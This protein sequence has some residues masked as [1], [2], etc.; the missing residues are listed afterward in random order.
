MTPDTTI[1]PPMR[2]PLNL[3]QEAVVSIIRFA[4]ETDGVEKA[5]EFFSMLNNYCSIAPGWTETALEIRKLFAELRAQEER[6]LKEEKEIEWKLAEQKT[7]IPQ[8]V[9]LNQNVNQNE[10]TGIAK[11][12][13]LNN[14]IEK[15]AEVTHTKQN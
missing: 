15:G 6:R 13:Q 10:S 8:V 2:G 5:K 7:A 9:V 14:G 12:D 11:V 1:T 4:I 3:T